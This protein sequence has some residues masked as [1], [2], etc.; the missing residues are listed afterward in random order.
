MAERKRKNN[1]KNE[2]AVVRTE[3]FDINSN[4]IVAD[5]NEKNSAK[6]TNG[7]NSAVDV[8]KF[9]KKVGKSD[10]KSTK[11]IEQKIDDKADGVLKLLVA[12][13]AQGFATDVVE[14]AREA[15]ADGAFFVEG[16]GFGKSEKKFFGLNIEPE[17]EIVFMAVPEKICVKVAKAIYSICRFTDAS[18]CSVF[19]LPVMSYFL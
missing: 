11:K 18:R 10:K 14:A 15:G 5:K 3:N 19:V 6:K 8:K 13:V 17:T 4:K 12:C 7:K 1:L 2:V 9:E 16:R